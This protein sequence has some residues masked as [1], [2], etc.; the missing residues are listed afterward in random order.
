MKHLQLHNLVAAC[1][2]TSFILLGVFFVLSNTAVVAPAATPGLD[3]TPSKT[4]DSGSVSASLNQAQAPNPSLP[5]TS[6]QNAV[7]LADK[8]MAEPHVASEVN[9]ADFHNFVA[10]V[11]NGQRDV[12][13]GV[14]VRGILAFSIIQQPENNPIFVSNKHD[15]VTQFQ[16]AARNGVTGLLAHNYLAGSLFYKLAPGYEVLIVYGDGTIQRYRVVSIHR[17]QKLKPT[18]LHS[19]LVDLSTGQEL[20]TAEVFRR[21]YRGEH[22]VTF[23]TCLERNGRLDWG[24][25]FVVAVPLFENITD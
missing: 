17:F 8:L 9:L 7:P 21:F 15:R 11:S 4:I 22:H 13:R 24:F 5:E 2:A 12:L 18:R 16:S 6:S 19:K 23:Q 20:S 10:Q 1:L 3:R 25:L 14:Y